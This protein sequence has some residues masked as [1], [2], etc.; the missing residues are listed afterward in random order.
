[1]LQPISVL[2][3]AVDGQLPGDLVSTRA[4]KALRR[5]AARV[6]SAW[7]AGC[8]ECRLD[9]DSDQNDLLV[10]ATRGAGGQKHLTGVL[11]GGAGREF[12]QARALLAQ[13]A[14]GRSP[15]A[16]ELATVW[17]E[18]DLPVDGSEP[19]P[20]AFI[21]LYP[22]YLA[23]GYPRHVYGRPISARR[24]RR[25]AA[26]G[27]GAALGFDPDSHALD[28]VA[29]CAACLPANG[30]MF[31]VVAMPHRNHS[32]LRIGAIVPAVGLRAWLRSVGWPGK[33]RQV[34]VL[35]RVLGGS[36]EL[37]HVQLELG[38]SIRA[39][40]SIDFECLVPPP[41]S[42][43]WLQFVERLCK[44]GCCERDRALAAVSWLRS[45]PVRLPGETLPLRMDQQLF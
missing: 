37:L 27:L 9:G 13:W 33:K 39:K 23:D 18:Y 19:D 41:Q 40:L 43:R 42:P 1:M 30:R 21:C 44:T 12:G 2:L 5:R 17:L 26:A 16:R 20:F 29:H 7:F 25:V 35:E 36:T 11:K 34:D 6:P 3:K 22:D 24:T 4:R 31:H 28:L 15:L 14:G 45:R 10:Y 8:V 38:D 32:D